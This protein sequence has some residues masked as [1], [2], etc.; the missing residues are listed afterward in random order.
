MTDKPSQKGPLAAGA[1][2][3]IAAA[4]GVASAEL[5]EPSEGMGPKPGAAYYDPAHILTQCYGETRDV[6]R[7]RIYNRDECAVKLRRRMARDYAPAILA[8]IPELGDERRVKVF[9]ALLDAAYNAGP[10]AVCNS[11]MKRSIR[12][13]DWVGGCNG[14]YGWYATAR[15]RRTGKRIALRGLQI[16]RQKEAALC[17]AGLRP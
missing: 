14:F 17:L 16:R 9:A 8:C 15:D 12:A 6:D 3:I 10:A 5:T 13:G 2:L 4:V 11:R 7:S 1:A